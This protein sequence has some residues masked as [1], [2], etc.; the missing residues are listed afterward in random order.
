MIGY[1]GGWSL[2]AEWLCVIQYLREAH[3]NALAHFRLSA[4]RETEFRIKAISEQRLFVFSQ[5]NTGEIWSYGRNLYVKYILGETCGHSS[6]PAGFEYKPGYYG[7][8]MVLHKLFSP[9]TRRDLNEAWLSV[10]IAGLP[11]SVAVRTSGFIGNK[12]VCPLQPKQRAHYIFSQNARPSA[13]CLH[14][15]PHPVPFETSE[16]VSG[17]SERRLGRLGE[18]F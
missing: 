7:S 18:P 3:I 16:H 2:L 15:V 6:A 4:Y 10:F 8:I 17:K 1:E 14:L 13:I 12:K 9:R 11:T 5:H